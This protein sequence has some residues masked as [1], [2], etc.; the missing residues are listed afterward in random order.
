MSEEVHPKLREFMPVAKSIAA[1]FGNMCE[2]VIHDFKYPEKS[3][4][5]IFGKLTGRKL[6]APITNL[7]LET[8][9]KN[10]DKSSN[11]IGYQTS[12]KD[13]KILKSSTIFIRDETDKIIGCMCI[14]F[15][16]TELL[17]CQQILDNFTKMV[18]VDENIGSSE[19]FYG[20]VNE[21]L[22]SIIKNVIADYPTPQQLMT[23]EDKLNIVKRLDG[24]GVFLVKGAVDQVAKVLGVS[25]YTIYNYLEEARSKPVSAS[26][27]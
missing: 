22:N 25:R 19:E 26:A 9:R 20:D 27:F 8:L 7:V 15:N 5:Y 17:T 14:N 16:L 11:L 10:G 4:V 23:K 24:K 1:T 13:G 6:G 2:V 3:L 12:T 21:V 18:S